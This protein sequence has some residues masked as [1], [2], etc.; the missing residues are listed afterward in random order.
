MRVWK[1]LSVKIKSTVRC[2]IPRHYYT[3]ESWFHWMVFFGKRPVTMDGLADIQYY[4]PN[5]T[6]CFLPAAKLSGPWT[7]EVVVLFVVCGGAF[8]FYLIF[9]LIRLY[10]FTSGWDSSPFCSTSLLLHKCI[11]GWDPDYLIS[12]VFLSYFTFFGVIY[13]FRGGIQVP[14]CLLYSVLLH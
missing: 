3:W 13:S 1:I 11:S 8:C 9:Q 6:I 7:M 10:E 4:A 2:S 14:C 12:P 5:N